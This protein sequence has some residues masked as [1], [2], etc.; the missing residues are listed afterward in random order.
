MSEF[1]T[2]AGLSTTD[3]QP[4]DFVTIGPNK[5]H[6]DQSFSRGVFKVCAANASHVLVAQTY[7]T[8]PDY[9]KGPHLLIRRHYEFCE[10]GEI[11]R[12]LTDAS[13]DEAAVWLGGSNA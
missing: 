9:F 11:Y 1:L 5:V 10:A 7:P 4:G 6:G 13:P 8:P 12:A 3:L 2:Q